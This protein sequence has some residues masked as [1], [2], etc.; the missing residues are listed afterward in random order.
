MELHIENSEPDV[1][2]GHRVT[3][4]KL[5]SRIRF[6]I[7]NIRAS[8]ANALANVLDVGDDLIAAQARVTGPWQRW[9]KDNCF[10]SLSTAKLYVQLAEHRAEIEAE[11]DRD[12]TLSLRAARKL[13]AKKSENPPE[14]KSNTRSQAAAKSSESV[15][16]RES[17]ILR[18][19]LGHVRIATMPETTPAGVKNAETQALVAL[20]ALATVLA[21]VD[22][23]C[24]SIV[25]KY[26]KEKRC[27]KTKKARRAA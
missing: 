25:N 4:E 1:Q 19:A 11:I 7:E 6:G 20:R 18:T 13:I 3:L 21:D 2:E 15:L 14:P 5:A 16:L 22:T 9:L 10:L 17:E 8:L 26:A 27:A 24:I 23:D 12:G